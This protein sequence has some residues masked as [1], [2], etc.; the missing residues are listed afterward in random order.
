[1][2][3]RPAKAVRVLQLVVYDI[4]GIESGLGDLAWKRCS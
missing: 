2:R 1:M 4:Q 3:E